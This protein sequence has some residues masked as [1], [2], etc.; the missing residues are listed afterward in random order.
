MQ[1]LL[2]VVSSRPHWLH[3]PLS[4]RPGLTDPVLTCPFQPSICSNTHK[5]PCGFIG[6]ALHFASTL[7]SLIFIRRPLLSAPFQPSSTQ[8]ITSSTVIFSFLSS[9]PFLLCHTILFQ[10]YSFIFRLIL[11]SILSSSYFYSFP[12]FLFFCV[13]L[14]YSRCIPSSSI[15]PLYLFCYLSY[16]DSFRIILFFCVVPFSSGYIPSYFI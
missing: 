3:P 11:V 15:P 8:L 2:G 14:F 6:L 7:A 13:V 9:I 1:S 16:F 12:I 10:L 4:L 5:V